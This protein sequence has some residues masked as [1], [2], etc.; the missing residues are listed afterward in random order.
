MNVAAGE[1][2]AATAAATSPAINITSPLVG[3]GGE[4]EPVRLTT[5]GYEGF[6]VGHLQLKV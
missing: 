2:G 4:R 1:G 3:G 5:P 6:A